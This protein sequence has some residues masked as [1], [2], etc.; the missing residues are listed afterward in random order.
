MAKINKAHSFCVQHKSNGKLTMFLLILLNVC[1]IGRPAVGAKSLYI[2]DPNRSTVTRS[3]G[4]IGVPVTYSVAGRFMLSI[5]DR[6]S[7]A[8]EKVDAVLTDEAG[9]VYSQSLDEVFNMNGLTGDP[10]G[11]KTIIFIGKTADGTGSDV[12][13]LL[14]FEDDSVRLKGNTTPPPNSADMFIYDVNAVAIRK[15][16]GG[17][18]E[19]ND[20]YQIAT[21]EDLIT[22]GETPEEYDKNFILT[23]DIDLDPNLPGCKVFDN[24]VIAPDAND[25]MDGFKGTPFS[26]IFD[27]NAHTISHLTITGK[28]YLG[29][30]GQLGNGAIISELGLD[31]IDVEGTD[32]CLG[33]L[34]GENSGGI[35]AD[36][37]T[38]G[39][40][41]GNREVGGL[42]GCNSKGTVAYCYS[43]GKVLGE[44]RIGGLV[45]RNDSEITNCYAA[46][47][48]LGNEQVGGLVGYS[49]V[50]FIMSSQITNCYFLTGRDDGGPD[51]GHGFPLT[52]EQMKKPANFFGWDFVGK[53]DGP[54]DIWAEPVKGGYPILWWQL[55]PLPELPFLSGKGVTNDPYLISTAD[56]LNNIGHNPRLMNAHFRL[57]DDIDLA[58]I[59]FFIIGSEIFPFNGV[60]DGNGHT[61]SHFNHITKYV[62]FVGLFGYAR[63]PQAE[64][65]D[66]GLINPNIEWASG[67]VG[68]LVGCFE[69]GIISNCYSDGGSVSG[70]G[71]VGGLVGSID[72]SMTDCHSSTTVSGMESVGGLV[73]S[74]IGLTGFSGDQAGPNEY[75]G[76]I[77]NCYSTGRVSGD[78]NVGGLVGTNF[79]YMATS[80]TTG[81]I[82]GV[83][84]VGGLT[85]RNLFG[86]ITNCYSTAGVIGNVS[87]GGLVGMNDYI[88]TISNCYSIG[89]VL[90][91]GNTGGMVGT[92]LFGY[93][94]NCYT[95]ATVAGSVYVG[96]LVGRN[97]EGSI[98]S[99]YSTGSVTGTEKVGGLVGENTPIPD[100]QGQYNMGTISS[101]FW[102]METSGQ[103]N[104]AGGTGLTTAEMQT[105]GAFIEAG[106]DFVGETDNGTEDIW[107]ILEGQDYPRLWWE[108]SD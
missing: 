104:S 19:P 67:S 41:N 22:L 100:Q 68:S 73:G 101:S 46:N 23:A 45:G 36:C 12:A 108:L 4:F 56:E 54:H 27:G 28:S 72:G 34:V 70:Y 2:F 10:N 88:G 103:S 64:I 33:G 38:S 40:I 63:G 25:K 3:G 58:G 17:T 89:S 91:D 81:S 99:S 5:D 93:M 7:A 35:I 80:Y 92:N 84:F 32:D 29:L 82:S 65:R 94:M 51:N 66:L 20:P 62:D 31:A 53:P 95:R 47:R 75:S 106:W 1:V 83:W 8:F 42:V 76:T 6:G 14:T 85:G 9:S 15:Y 50:T 98:S 74:A 44:S 11:I 86:H 43:T 61:I 52:D 24:A 16:A 48:V 13:I 96:G 26:G 55:S 21:A 57:A 97:L 90:G 18:G 77:S 39:N 59:D 60:F 107:W 30:F 105:A 49:D 71:S 79:G 78:R 37:Y 69:D 87:V 102:D